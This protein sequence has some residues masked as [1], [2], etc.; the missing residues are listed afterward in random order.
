MKKLQKW[1]LFI[2]GV[3]ELYRQIFAGVVTEQHAEQAGEGAAPA[4]APESLEKLENE[5]EEARGQDEKQFN[6]AKTSGDKYAAMRDS[7]KRNR[8]RSETEN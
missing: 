3:I 1:L 7:I 6:D 5:I 4:S 8:M 2:R